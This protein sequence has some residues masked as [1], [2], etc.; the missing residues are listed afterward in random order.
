MNGRKRQVAR[1]K[2][3]RKHVDE[4]CGTERVKEV[5]INEV[6]TDK[7]KMDR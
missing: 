5:L 1:R 3:A 7:L 2:H 4:G 6:W